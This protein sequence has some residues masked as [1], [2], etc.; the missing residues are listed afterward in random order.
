MSGERRLEILSSPGFLVGLS[1]LLTNDFVLKEQFHNAFTGKLSHL[2]DCL[3][4]HSSG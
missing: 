3:C 1:L 2:P 4:S